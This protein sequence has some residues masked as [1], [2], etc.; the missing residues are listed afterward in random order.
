MNFLLL[1]L[2]LFFVMSAEVF[3]VCLILGIPIFFLSRWILKRSIKHNRA[4]IVTTW[5]ITIVG[6]YLLYHLLIALFILYLVYEPS[7]SFDQSAWKN[8][9]ND[10]FEMADDLI[11]SR[12]LIAKDSNQVIHVLGKP[13][14]RLLKDNS[15]VYDM[16]TGTAG[17]GF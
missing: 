2:P 1:S 17:L 5:T 13:N 9:K 6:S 16:G 4:R 10:R 7:R 15:F 12:I 11:K 8:N 3:M 14:Y